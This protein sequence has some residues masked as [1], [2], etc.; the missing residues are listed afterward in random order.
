M[1]ETRIHFFKEGT[2]VTVSKVSQAI[3]RLKK[4]VFRIKMTKRRK[5]GSN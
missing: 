5:N 3:P 2:A 1:N 4:L